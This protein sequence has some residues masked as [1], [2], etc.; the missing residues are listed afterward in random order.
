L[1]KEGFSILLTAAGEFTEIQF[2]MHIIFP[3][4]K[5]FPTALTS[6]DVMGIKQFR[7]ELLNGN[8]NS[9]AAKQYLF[10]KEVKPKLS[11]KLK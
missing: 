2:Y 11:S 1:T 6:I 9:F 5:I 3:F 7:K 4:W 10:R 8:I